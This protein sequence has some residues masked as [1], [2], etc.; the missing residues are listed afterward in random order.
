M[1]CDGRCCSTFT[2]SKRVQ[3]KLRHREGTDDVKWRVPDGDMIAAMIV[4]LGWLRATI[5]N[6][7]L[8]Y[9][10]KPRHYWSMRGV[11]F[12][13]RFWD[14]KTKLCRVYA[15]RPHLCR[16]YAVTNPTTCQHGCGMECGA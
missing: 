14:T 4:R 13:C 15:N 10:F 2:L 3:E 8:G 1:K 7:R 5:R 9:G 12:T 16:S 6:W 11:M